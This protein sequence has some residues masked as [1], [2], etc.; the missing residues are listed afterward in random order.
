MMG[1]ALSRIFGLDSTTH[2]NIYFSFSFFLIREVKEIGLF[3]QEGDISAAL[4]VVPLLS[5]PIIG[6]TILFAAL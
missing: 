6:E 3:L 4:C 2:L 5:L 1:M